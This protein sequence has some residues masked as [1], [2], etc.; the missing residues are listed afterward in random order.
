M[1]YRL[2]SCSEQR[3][4]LQPWFE[5]TGRLSI[6]K[7][8]TE[9]VR[10]SPPSR[11]PMSDR[12]T[13]TDSATAVLLDRVRSGDGAARDHLMARFLPLLQRWAR[14]RLPAYARSSAETDD[15][16]QV[17]L[18]R[19]LANV[20][21]FEN[22]GEG[23]FLAYL[24][25]ILLNAVRDE[26]RRASRRPPHDPVD[27]ELRD[28]APSVVEQA[29]GRQAMARYEAALAALEPRQREAVLLRVEFGYSYAQVSEAIAGASANAAR[30]VVSRA[31]AKM[32]EEME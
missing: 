20:E 31:L 32:A 29:I 2:A 14:G 13:T 25:R 27:S 26:I 21:R 22:R 11:N 30:M 19:A 15:L 17:S 9:P 7:P 24:R 4:D 5:R 10:V 8:A 18:V 1:S 23:A 6:V 28:H 16:V 12:F 3:L